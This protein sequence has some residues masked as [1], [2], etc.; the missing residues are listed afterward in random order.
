MKKKLLIAVISALL[1]LNTSFFDG[2]AFA[3]TEDTAKMVASVSMRENPSLSSARIRYLKQGEVVDIVN[4][5]NAYWYKVRDNNNR[6]GYVSTSEKY[7]TLSSGGT[8]LSDTHAQII[9]SVSFR[10]G[11]STDNRRIRYLKEGNK[12]RFSK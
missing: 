12:L 1:L 5:V 7:I 9:N 6:I 2:Q 3:S 11:P 4:K 8:F 10:I